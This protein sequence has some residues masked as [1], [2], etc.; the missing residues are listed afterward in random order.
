MRSPCCRIAEEEIVGVKMGLILVVD[1]AADD[2]LN[3]VNYRILCAL[4]V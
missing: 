2:K 4:Q 3:A 1:A